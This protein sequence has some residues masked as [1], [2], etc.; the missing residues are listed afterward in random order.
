MQEN[1][2]IVHVKGYEAFYGV[3]RDGRVFSFN[4][5]R[6]GKLK[7]LSLCNHG[8]CNDNQYKTVHLKECKKF[9]HRLVA[10]AFIENTNNY[11]CVNHING[12]KSDN[13]A[14]NLEW[15]SHSVNNSHAYKTGLKSNAGEKQSHHKLTDKQVIEIRRIFESE[16]YHGQIKD[17]AKKYRITPSSM[18]NI[19]KRISWS[20]I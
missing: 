19:K 9:V 17:M 12:I 18:R 6:T 13:N 10:E 20:H 8:R 16:T 1:Q 15:V 14:S 3:T 7:E 2:E 5:K 11:K 4:Y